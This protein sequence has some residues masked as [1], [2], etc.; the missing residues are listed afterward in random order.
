MRNILLVVLSAGVTILGVIW[1]GDFSLALGLALL[2]EQ[3]LATVLALALGV[4]YLTYDLRSKPQDNPP[5]YD[6]VLAALGLGFG[7][8]L[9]VQYPALSQDAFYRPIETNIVGGVLVVLVAEGLRRT[10]GMSLFLV[11]LGFIAYALFGHLVPGKMQG[12]SLPPDTFFQF[13]G[14]D[15]VAMLGL[16]MTVITSVVIVF[17]L[18]GQLLLQAG[19][20]TFFTDIAAAL[21]GRSRGG[22]AKIAVVASGLFGSIS[23]SAVSNVVSTGVITIPLMKNSGYRP[24]VAGAIEAVASTGGQIMPPIMGAAAFLMVELLGTSYQSVV[25]AALIPSGLYFL[26]VFVQADLEAAKHG[27][28][29]VPEDKIPAARKVMKEGWYFT[30][31][32]AVLLYALFEW[33][34][35]PEK[36]ALYGLAAIIVLGLIFSYQGM[37]LTPRSLWDSLIIAGRSSVD[38]VV[39]GAAAGIILGILDR[40]GLSFGLT[41]I[42]V[43]LGGNSLVALLAMTAVVGII[44]GM[45][46]PTT[47]IYFL[48]AT[49]AAP[50]IIKLGV[51]PMAAHMFVLYFGM[52][53]MITPPVALA[54]FTAAKLADASPMATAVASCRFGF[55]AFIIPFLFVLAPV[56]IMKG[57]PLAIFV[58]VVTAIAGIWIT[59]GGLTGYLFGHLGMAMRLGMIIAGLGLLLPSQTFAGAWMFEVAGAILAAILLAIQYMQGRQAVRQAVV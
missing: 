55:P 41:I 26:S 23:G 35:Q 4:I 44:L 29:P 25:V 32:F 46:M 31:P 58:A 10:S 37:R 24:A 15:N 42:L 5:W 22:S 56:L 36:A 53:S 39:I 3:L 50:P 59:S 33:N 30:V 14:I 38:I 43:E 34:V 11:L 18:F 6:W 27:I 12:R 2:P 21:M 48:L 13:L 9:A 20:S 45:G 28:A 7:L 40:T 51:D 19:G 16:P 57:S 8:Y 49:L 54:A 17:V 1:A 52:M 47:A